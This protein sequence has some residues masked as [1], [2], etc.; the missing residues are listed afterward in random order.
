[1][2]KGFTNFLHRNALQRTRLQ[3]LSFS[4]RQLEDMGISR[5]LL[6]KGVDE[7]PWRELEEQPNTV[8]ATSA[9][10]STEIK[11]AVRELSAMSDQQ[12]RDIGVDRGSIRY[13]VSHG[14]TGRD[15]RQAA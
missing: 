13:A 15:P 11:K 7:W 10:T 9:L 6:T 12:L 1:M 2:F 4:D 5:H 3:L 14:I 8:P